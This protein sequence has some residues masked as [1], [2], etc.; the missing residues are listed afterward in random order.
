MSVKTFTGAFYKTVITTSNAGSFT[1]LGNIQIQWQK[2]ITLY[3]P[4]DFSAPIKVKGKLDG[5]LTISGMAITASDFDR[6]SANLPVGAINAT[7]P[8]QTVVTL[9]N[10]SANVAYT[11]YETGG[12]FQFRQIAE[13]TWVLDKIVTLSLI[14]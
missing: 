6:L 13:R 9:Y 11:G 5:T 2:P 3:K 4:L 7:T 10:G 14:D 8:T 12:G 1:G